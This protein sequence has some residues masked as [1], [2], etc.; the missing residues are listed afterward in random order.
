MDGITPGLKITNCIG[1]VMFNNA[2]I[3][4]GRV[5][6][7]KEEFDDEGYKSS[8]EGHGTNNDYDDGYLD[9]EFDEIEPDEIIE[10]VGCLEC[11]S[12]A[13]EADRVQEVAS[14]H[15]EEIKEEDVEESDEDSNDNDNGNVDSSNYLTKPRVGA[16][17][18]YDHE[19]KYLWSAAEVCW[20]VLKVKIITCERKVI[21]TYLR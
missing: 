8:N 6:Y 19:V 17:F 12:E 2:G 21:E 1:D 13:E 16:H 5:D 3:A 7:A 14:N 18:T 20:N 9:K 11:K 4:G 15:G 10:L